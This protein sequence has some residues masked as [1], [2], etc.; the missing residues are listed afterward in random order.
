MK[1]I[2]AL[3]SRPEDSTSE[4]ESYL[5]ELIKLNLLQARLY[6][7]D[8]NPDMILEFTSEDALGRTET[9]LLTE[10]AEV[11]HRISA[12]RA[13]AVEVQQRIE[14]SREYLQA[15]KKNRKQEAERKDTKGGPEDDDMLADD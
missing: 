4:T 5:E 8:G 14:L 9:S 1:Y 6:K 11:K 10:H 2:P 12:L 3:I 7:R 13:R 15:A